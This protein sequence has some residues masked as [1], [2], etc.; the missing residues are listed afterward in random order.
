VS[1]LTTS[2]PTSVHVLQR[3]RMHFLIWARE[4]KEFQKHCSTAREVDPLHAR[5]LELSQRFPD[6]EDL[7]NILEQSSDWCDRMA[8]EHC[9]NVYEVR[10]SWALAYVTAECSV[11]KV[12]T[13][14]VMD[15]VQQ[16]RGATDAEKQEHM[17]LADVINACAAAH[18][19]GFDWSFEKPD[20]R[21]CR[22]SLTEKDDAR[23]QRRRSS[24]P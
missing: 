13:K 8:K 5:V 17:E 3:Q 23:P 14:D 18:N 16:W 22:S 6:D 9:K 19:A 21:N 24:S 4:F 15:D 7:K 20:L 10:D 2:E 12:T 1:E 11:R